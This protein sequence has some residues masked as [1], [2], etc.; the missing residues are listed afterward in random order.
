M[1]LI[2]RIL[3]TEIEYV[4]MFSNVIEDNQTLTFIDSAIPDMYTHNFV[5]YRSTEGLHAFISEELNKEANKAKGFFRIETPY[6]IDESFINTLPI[7][8]Q[9]CTY[10]L[11]A[12]ATRRYSQLNGN[13]DCHIL[14]ADTKKVLEDGISVDIAANQQGMGVD[15][16]TRRIN[17]KTH[18]YK[19]N[20]KPIQWF[21]CYNGDRPIG[22][23][24]YMPSNGIV[25]LEDFDILENFQKKGFGTSVLKCLLE[26]AFH[27][28]IDYAYLITDRS[29]TAKEM[30]KKCGLEKVGGKT[31]LLFF[32]WENEK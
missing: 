2:E 32:F 3:D 30:Y 13:P 25:K 12:I 17:R 8:P 1:E 27:D 5:L 9:I 22:N 26:K 14:C 7:K 4:K 28:N 15:F 24:E 16:A 31:E 29:D 23:I 20:E 11:M 19:N 6:P 21:V 18:V 10:D